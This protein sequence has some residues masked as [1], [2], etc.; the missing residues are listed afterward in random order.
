M[1]FAR[2]PLGTIE[3]SVR[4]MYRIVYFLRG[5]LYI[6]CIA[7]CN[8]RWKIRTHCVS[9]HVIC[10]EKSVRIKYYLMYVSCIITLRTY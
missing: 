3:T 8:L 10:T 9:Y 7:S 2:D 4:T 5:N 6:L 1:L